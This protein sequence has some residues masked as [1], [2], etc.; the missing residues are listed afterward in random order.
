MKICAEEDLLEEI[1]RLNKDPKVNGL[2]I[3]LP[4]PKHFN[5]TLI[6][7]AVAT[8]KDVDGFARYNVGELT[9]KGGAPIFKLMYPKWYNGID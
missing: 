9:K 8:E 5:E 4:L 6:T 2:L 1:D 3:Q 7:N